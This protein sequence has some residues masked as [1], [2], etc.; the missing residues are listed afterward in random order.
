MAG[1]TPNTRRKT[2]DLAF[3]EPVLAAFL[4][5][6]DATGAAVVSRDIS[7]SKPVKLLETGS[8]PAV[9]LGAEDLFSAGS[10][11]PP[12]RAGADIRPILAGPWQM[13][14]TQSTVVVFWREAGAKPW[15]K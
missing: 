3:L 2:L 15:T 11:G 1:A 9:L 10:R 6:L 5:P 13:L 14:P 12:H 4:A 7:G 8:V